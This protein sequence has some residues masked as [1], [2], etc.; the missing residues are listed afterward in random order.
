VPASASPAAESPI[1]PST[2]SHPSSSLV[3][4]P[5][6]VRR[7]ERP[8]ADAGGLQRQAA[9]PKSTIGDRTR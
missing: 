4:S 2:A 3:A 8:A 7:S 1:S 6:G 9:R 5:T